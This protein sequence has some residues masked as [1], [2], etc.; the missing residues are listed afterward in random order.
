MERGQGL[1]PF[2][3]SP[4]ISYS[5]RYIFWVCD[6]CK[7]RFPSPG[8]G[9]GKGSLRLQKPPDEISIDEFTE[10]TRESRTEEKTQRKQRRGSLPGWVV[11]VV[12]IFILLIAV[13]LAWSLKGDQ[14]IQFFSDFT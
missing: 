10:L 8:Y 4:Q 11:L 9:A 13:L 3:G 14:I 6:R 5:H 12:I 7:R 2:C 1:C